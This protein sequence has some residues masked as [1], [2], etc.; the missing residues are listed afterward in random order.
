MMPYMLQYFQNAELYLSGTN[1]LFTAGGRKMK[2]FMTTAAVLAVTI[3]MACLPAE[4]HAAAKKKTVYV[5]SGISVKEDGK[6]TSVKPTYTKDGLLKK[7]KWVLS[8][9]TYTDSFT[10]GKKGQIKQNTEKILSGSHKGQ[11]ATVKYTWKN[12]R[13]TQKIEYYAEGDSSTTKYTYDAKGRIASSSNGH[14]EIIF[15]YKKG[16]VVKSEGDKIKYSASLDSKGNVKK[17]TRTF[18]GQKIG[19]YSAKITYK[20]GRVKKLTRIFKA[21]PM[22]EKE[23]KQTLTFTYKKMRVPKSLADKIADQQW[24]FINHAAD[25]FAW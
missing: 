19:Y 20:S 8:D 6:K 1:T 2:R 13:L 7:I 23:Q 10:Y 9:E 15:T 16:H 5:I 14:E 25:S 21:N 18:D 22:Q 11:G 4:V 24:Q 17:W 3:C 12:G